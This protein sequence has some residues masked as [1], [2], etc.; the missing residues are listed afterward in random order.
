MTDSPRVSVVIPSYRRAGTI[1]ACVEC[2]LAQTLRDIEVIVVDDASGDGTDDV[3]RSIADDRVRLVTHEAN[4]G[5][6]A[7]RA[8]GIASSTGTYVAFLDSDDVWLPTKLERQVERLAQAGP[9]YGLCYTWYEMRDQHGTVVG[10]RE[11]R[12]EGLAVPE[13]L[14]H[15]VIGTYSTVLIDRETLLAVGGPDV[16]MKA[17]Q[18]WELYLRLNLVT[19]ICVVPEFL[20]NYLRDTDDEV[21]I[22]TRRSAVVSGHRAV[23]ARSRPRFRELD[24]SQLVEALRSYL[25][26]FANA[27]AITD[28]LHVAADLPRRSWNPSLGRF[29]AH[30]TARSVRKRLTIGERTH[31]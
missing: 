2:A 19:G 15:N 29:V 4:Q 30:M 9:E 5:G 31:E 22:S 1:C 23:Y 14:V 20:V 11:P 21:R 10:R 26:I 27:G 13:L 24:D 6:N 18:D 7:A 3:V 28:V 25:E 16:S 8:T 17:C 12:T